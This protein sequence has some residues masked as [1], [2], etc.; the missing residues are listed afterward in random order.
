MNNNVERA[1]DQIERAQ[2][3]YSKQ[4][5]FSNDAE[6]MY[7]GFARFLETLDADTLRIPEYLPDSRKRDKFLQQ[8]WQY[9]PHWAGILNQAILV[10]SS[11]GWEVVGGR[12]QVNRHV[13][14]MHDA[15]GGKGW[16][17]YFRKE[18]LSYR[19]TDLGATT[20]EGREGKAG[21]LRAI[22]HV[23]SARCRWTGKSNT[24]LQYYPTRG[25][26]QLWSPETFFNV[27]SMPSDRESYNSLGYCMTSR[28]FDV[29]RLMYAVLIHDTEM[30]QA[31]MPRGLLLLSNIG[32]PQWKT[33][34]QSRNAE[35]KA[36]GREYFGGVM[37]LA[38][39]GVEQA[40]AK[41]IGLSQLPA[42]FDRKTFIDQ[43]MYA[44]AL[45]AGF[46]PREFWPVSGG[47]L[48]S[49]TETEEMARKTTTKGA[50]E[51]PHAWQEQ[52]QRLLPESIHFEF[53]ERDLRGELVEAEV[54]NAWGAFLQSVRA[55]P[56][57]ESI[58]TNEELRQFLAMK[59][60]IPVEWTEAE[61][62]A[63]AT[64]EQTARCKRD[65]YKSLTS[66]RRA[67]KCF[68]SDPIVRYT[69]STSATGKPVENET[70]LWLSGDELL[71]PEYYAVSREN[72]VLFDEDGVKITTQDVDN[73]IT[74]V[75]QLLGDEQ[76]DTL[77]DSEIEPLD[78]SALVNL[79]D[80][81]MLANETMIDALVPLDKE[82]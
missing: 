50:L 24:P 18:S 15:D 23:D 40:D 41:L 1:I 73:A 80:Q 38:G 16:R 43:T 44:Y 25:K 49:A 21:P 53:E 3:M 46:D 51:F 71:K 13:T 59:G 4:P 10:D 14:M 8:I 12:N 9:E 32:E 78:T 35:Q 34:L 42:N 26:N 11:R 19:V 36:L 76:A 74:E 67:A 27:S 61:E 56:S 45:I 65:Y 2:K 6:S 54:A 81:L 28:A 22:Y 70:V 55:D 52:F 39:A 69:Y 20:E 62:D 33:A 68:P 64:D 7:S 48:G 82:E 29:M 60:V 37:I 77:I 66:V 17:M 72:K 79:S 75:R 63:I 47:S 58:L 31:K 30:A 5:R 57:N